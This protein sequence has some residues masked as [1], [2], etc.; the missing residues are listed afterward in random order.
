MSKIECLY[1]AYCAEQD[2]EPVSPAYLQINQ[3]LLGMLPHQEYMEVEELFNSYNHENEK[4]CFYAGFRA[5]A[6]LWAE[7][8]V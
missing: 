2:N 1:Q 8:I 4:A 3:I 7:A 6:K 5:A